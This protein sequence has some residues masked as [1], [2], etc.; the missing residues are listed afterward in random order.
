MWRMTCLCCPRVI[1]DDRC[2]FKKHRGCSCSFYMQMKSMCSVEKKGGGGGVGKPIQKIW[3]VLCF[4]DLGNVNQ[5]SFEVFIVHRLRRAPFMPAVNMETLTFLSEMKLHHK[6]KESCQQGNVLRL[7]WKKTLL[8]KGQN[9]AH[10][11][12]ATIWS[13]ARLKASKWPKVERARWARPSQL[14]YLSGKIKY[15]YN[16]S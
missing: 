7:F 12:S 1:C 2:S 9:S 5:I 8:F 11:R 4:R 16:Q 10:L 6:L 3:P 14:L 13:C 15:T